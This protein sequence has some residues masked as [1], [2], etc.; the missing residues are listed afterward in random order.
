[1]E[2]D[3]SIDSIVGRQGTASISGGCLFPMSLELTFRILEQEVL[4]KVEDH[5][6]SPELG[7]FEGP[8][9]ISHQRYI[10]F[11]EQMKA[12][13]DAPATPP[14]YATSELGAGVT[15]PLPAETVE[16]G[17]CEM[18]EG[19]PPG[20]LITAIESFAE[21][22]FERQKSEPTEPSVHP[23][24]ANSGPTR[25][26][27]LA[28]ARK[29][30][31]FLLPFSI[32]GLVLWW[33]GQQNATPV[34]DSCVSSSQCETHLCNITDTGKFWIFGMEGYCTQ[35]CGGHFGPCPATTTCTQTTLTTSRGT[36]LAHS[37]QKQRGYFCVPQ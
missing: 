7:R 10:R 27:R 15:L 6:S 13:L 12:L 9:R 20:P 2:H 31:P 3:S 1:M 8:S 26:G 29:L 14:T 28:V 32:F 34:G 18:V 30:L 19:P 23:L 25:I 33:Y 11:A 21:E 4:V 35:H 5:W 36:G 22:I 37:F 24:P 16:G 17:G